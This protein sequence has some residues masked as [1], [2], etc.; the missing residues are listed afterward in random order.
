MGSAALDLATDCNGVKQVF[1]KLD[2]GITRRIPEIPDDVPVQ[3]FARIWFTPRAVPKLH[4]KQ[5]PW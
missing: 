4:R 1:S 3:V 5:S 2:R